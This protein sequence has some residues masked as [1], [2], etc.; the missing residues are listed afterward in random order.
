MAN[1]TSLSLPGE[2]SKWD[3]RMAIPSPSSS[4]HLGRAARTLRWYVRDPDFLTRAPTAT[5]PLGKLRENVV[6][7]LHYRVAGGS[8]LGVVRLRRL[9]CQR[10]RPKCIGRGIILKLAIAPAA[11]VREPLAILHHEINVMERIRHQRLTGVRRV[12]LGVPMN[13]RHFGA[14]WERLAVTGNARLKRVDHRGI[15]EDHGHQR[16]IVTDGNHLPKL[17]SLELG[18]R[19]PVRHFE[20]VPVLRRNRSPIGQYGERRRDAYTDQYAFAFHRCSSLIRS[21]NHP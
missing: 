6:L 15:P 5:S 11:A 7:L 3:T 17:V 12:G 16:S 14:F 19:E 13:L 9:I 1:S 10:A 18:E 8:A 2:T 4:C 21:M 20:G